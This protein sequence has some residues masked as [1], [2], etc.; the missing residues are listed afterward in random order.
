MQADAGPRWVE[1]DLDAI[2]HNVEAVK[3]LLKPETRL[4]AVVKADAYGFGAV[5]VSK[6]VLEAGA[7]MLAVTTIDEGVELREQGVEAPILVFAPFFPEEWKT[8]TACNLTGT[9]TGLDFLETFYAGGNLNLAD[10]LGRTRVHI[11]VNTGMNRLGVNP[12]QVVECCRAAARIPGLEVEGVYSHFATTPAQGK[13]FMEKQFQVFSRVTTELEQHNI[14]IPI[15]HICNSAATLD[16]PEMHL[17][18]VRVGNLLYGQLPHGNRTEIQL[19][20]PWKARAKIV[21]VRQVF[22]GEAVGYGCDYS[23]WFC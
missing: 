10:I 17:D 14:H 23:P 18:L 20:D 11:K 7:E 16:M 2:M 13:P 15:K 8:A 21:S 3:S 22:P 9:V 19:K 6:A 1:I 12:E 5:E 4:M